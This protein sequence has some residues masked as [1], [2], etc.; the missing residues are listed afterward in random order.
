M[1]KIAV[2][3]QILNEVG[4]AG[5]APK[6]LRFESY[7]KIARHLGF[8]NRKE[9]PF[10]AVQMVRGRFPEENCTSYTGFKE[11]QAKGKRGLYC[12]PEE[13]DMENQKKQKQ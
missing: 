13:A 1:E 7:K 5:S 4:K 10:Y 9:L 12:S 6:A 8:S 11:K 3:S 2:I